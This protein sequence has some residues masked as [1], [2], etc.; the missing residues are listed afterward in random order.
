MV[1][2]KRC[3]TMISNLEKHLNPKLADDGSEDWDFSESVA[4]PLVKSGTFDITVF[5]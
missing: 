1:K 3:S 5:S 2:M 4:G